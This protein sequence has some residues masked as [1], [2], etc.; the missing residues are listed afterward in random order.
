[1]HGPEQGPDH[2]Q[3]IAVADGELL[4]DAEVVEPGHG[5]EGAYPGVGPGLVAQGQADDGDQDDV[6]AGDE[7]RLGGRGVEQ[8]H[9]L[10]GGGGEEHGAGDEAPGQQQAVIT[11]RLGRLA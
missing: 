7:A 10:Q 1:M 4:G 9:L 2:L 8:P 11:G 5:D 3:Q 6:E